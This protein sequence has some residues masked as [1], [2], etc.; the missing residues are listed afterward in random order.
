LTVGRVCVFCGSNSGGRPDYA[1]AAVALADAVVA[2]GA[3]LVYGGAA[4]GLMGVVADR[5]LAAGAD[6]IGVI[7]EHLVGREIAHGGLTD[8]LVVETMTERKALMADLAD[9]F[10]ALPGGFGTL[11]ELFEVL[12][13]SQ[14]GLHAKPTGLL[15]VDGFWSQLDGFLDHAV[16]EGFLRPAHRRMLLRDDDPARLLARLDQWEPPAVTKWI[17]PDDR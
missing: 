2:A 14:L 6:V 1:D 5:A 13:W 16:A 3:G 12:T 11:D 17:D 8:L 7:P 4:V 10:V 9:C 15:D